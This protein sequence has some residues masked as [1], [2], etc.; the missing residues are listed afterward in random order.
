VLG[1]LD[2]ERLALELSGVSR[3]YRSEAEVVW[4]ARQIDLTV[5]RGAMVCVFGASGSGKSTLLRMIAG[6][7]R[8]DTGRIAVRGIDLNN[9][10]DD[11]LTT[12]RRT[13]VGV[14]FQ[15]HRLIEEFTAA[16]N[17]ALPLEAA[18]MSPDQVR[19][20]THRTLA[21][22]DLTGLESRFP[23]QLSGGQQQRVG[24]ARALV[25]DRNLLLADEPTGAL[26]SANSLA[27][28]RLIRDLCDGGITAIVC[29]HDYR[30]RSFA[31][32]VYE[33]I[34]GRLHLRSTGTV[35]TPT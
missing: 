32:V 28:F 25:G 16:E 19:H 17:V 5:P 21:N 24:I 20:L 22:V 14:V 23:R 11:D 4:A 26:D 27:I 29:S 34:D 2:A 35:Q 13:D 15:D 7:D 8:P 12:L 9:L 3:S 18:G 6:L 31:D 10:S 30:C 33:M 1:E